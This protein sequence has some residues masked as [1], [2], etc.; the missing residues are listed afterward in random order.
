ME[1]KRNISSFIFSGI[2]LLSVLFQSFH[3]YEH[4]L[5]K[6]TEKVCE[7]KHKKSGSYLTHEHSKFE[8]CFVCQ[9]NFSPFE[10]PESLSLQIK[11]INFTTKI[12]F[13]YSKEIL[14]LYSGSLL[15]L[16]G[17]PIV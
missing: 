12:S 1:N 8:N 3:S 7:H 13:F 17:P 10:L 9:F 5:K 4:F 6:T 16:R 15:T 14:I 11:K 2:V